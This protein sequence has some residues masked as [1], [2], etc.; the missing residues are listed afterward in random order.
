MTAPT[1]QPCWY[2]L[3]LDRLLIGLLAWEC[4][5]WLSERFQ[6]FFFNHHR[7]RD[8][9]LTVA[10]VRLAITNW[11]V[12]LC[13]A[14][15][16][17]VFVVVLLWFIVALVFRWRFQFGIRSL[18]ILML[19]VA[20]ACSWISWDMRDVERQRRATCY[21]NIVR[22][23]LRW[24]SSNPPPCK[25]KDIVYYATLACELSDW[26]NWS[27]LCTLADAYAENGEFEKAREAGAKALALAWDEEDRQECR[28]RME[29]ISSKTSRT[30]APKPS[31][32]A[33][34]GRK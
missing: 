22:L 19:V 32:F 21:D 5:L 26:N 4:L 13:V 20:V 9:L 11:A 34:G 6:W 33:C 31:M 30:V 3:T 16:G 10:G 15:V 2:R 8:V 12:L 23:T 18:L 25:R 29:L 27:H 7:G 1:P 14:S 17:V 28:T 24:V